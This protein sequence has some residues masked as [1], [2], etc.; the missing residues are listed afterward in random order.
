MFTTAVVM[1]PGKTVG[2]AADGRLN[3]TVKSSGSSAMLST[4]I[5]IMMQRVSLAPVLKVTEYGPAA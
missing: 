5:G 2:F 4:T 1:A 3:D